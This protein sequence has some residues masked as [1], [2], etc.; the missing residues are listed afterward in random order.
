[1]RWDALFA[2]LEAQ[3]EAEAARELAAEVGERTR[4]E[5]SALHVTDRL[6]AAQGHPVVV[7]AL[8][9]TLRGAVL[10]VGPDW[11]LV[12]VERNRQALVRLGAVLGVTGLGAH[13]SAPDGQGR[14]AA[15]LGLAS[16]LRA[17]A[18]DRAP[19]VITRIDGSTLTG[20]LDRVGADFLEIAEHPIGEARRKGAVTDV[21]VVPFAAVAVVDSG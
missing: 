8:G 19:V 4:I 3:A 11:V 21:R 18:R 7:S 13:S 15:R 6:R 1:V 5:T 9:A 20:T 14:V 17:V 2:D 12:E 16:A 10:G